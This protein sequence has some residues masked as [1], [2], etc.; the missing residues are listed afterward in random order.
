MSAR[1]IKLNNIRRK[2]VT[3]IALVVV[4]NAYVFS[5]M[6]PAAVNIAE[7]A[8]PKKI[9][10]QGKL[11]AVSDGTNVSNGTYAFRFKYLL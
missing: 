6:I 1:I 11:T 3:A 9:N 4:F 5:Y 2:V 7:A 8:V 10:F